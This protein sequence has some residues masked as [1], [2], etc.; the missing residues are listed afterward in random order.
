MIFSLGKRTVGVKTHHLCRQGRL[1]LV[2]QDT[3][4]N[5]VASV[6]VVTDK[7]FVINHG[8]PL[9]RRVLGF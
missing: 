1:L 8:C 9:P 3:L 2:S 5:A 7:L 6:Q 4:G